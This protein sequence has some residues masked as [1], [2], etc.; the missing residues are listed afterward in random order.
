MGVWSSDKPLLRTSIGVPRVLKVNWGQTVLCQDLNSGPCICKA[1]T[2]DHDISPVPRLTLVVLFA[3]IAGLV[4]ISF[5]VAPSQSA[6]TS[7]DV[8]AGL[9]HGIAHTWL[10]VRD[11]MLCSTWGCLEFAPGSASEI[12]RQCWRLNEGELNT[13]HTLL[14]ALPSLAATTPLLFTYL[15][16][17]MPPPWGQ[18]ELHLHAGSGMQHCLSPVGNYLDQSLDAWGLLGLCQAAG[19]HWM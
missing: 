7:F 11:Q 3:F 13:G 19:W 10:H 6:P 4:L 12:P 1:R 18:P 15:F 9:W 17:V 16:R 5:S 2:L 14:P 8:L